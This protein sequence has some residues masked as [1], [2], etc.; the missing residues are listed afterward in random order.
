MLDSYHFLKRHSV[1]PLLKQKNTESGHQIAEVRETL[2]IPLL[3]ELGFPLE[4]PALRQRINILAVWVPML[5]PNKTPLRED[6]T[7]V[8]IYRD[9]LGVL[10]TL[11]SGLSP[12][13][14][15]P[16]DNGEKMA[17]KKLLSLPSTEGVLAHIKQAGREGRLVGDILFNMA[18]MVEIGIKEPSF[19]KA[20]FLTEQFYKDAKF[21]DGSKLKIGLSEKPL[22]ASWNTY[23]F[24]AHFWAAYS[25]C[26]HETEPGFWDP[27]SQVWGPTF[28]NFLGVAEW[29][30]D[31]MVQFRPSR[32]Q[33]EPCLFDKVTPYRLPEGYLVHPYTPT[34]TDPNG[35]T[36]E[37]L[38]NYQKTRSKKIKKM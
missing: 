13:K 30:R 21:D 6:H 9:L 35:S 19:R 7:T 29:F 25:Y 32:S 18:L 12:A 31:F 15:K 17:G 33:K 4:E 26:Q 23:K 14:Y 3:N 22:R 5:Y 11:P 10:K 16:F 1:P 27:D 24:V 8:I 2:I 34:F 28:P 37:L 36:E 20:L 38:K